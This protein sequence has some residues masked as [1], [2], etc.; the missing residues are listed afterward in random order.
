MRRLVFVAVA[1]GAANIAI[2][3]PAQADPLGPSACKDQVPGEFIS[4]VAQEIG[5]GKEIHPR[6][7]V[8]FGSPGCNP[9]TGD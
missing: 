9:H 3:A 6:G 7:F 2:A 5:H 1:V 8:P 4:F